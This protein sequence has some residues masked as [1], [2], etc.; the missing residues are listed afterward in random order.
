MAASAGDAPT[1]SDKQIDVARAKAEQL[2][3]LVTV[4]KDILVILHLL[5]EFSEV[6]SVR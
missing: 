5:N 1:A 2:D 6:H 3:S 4:V